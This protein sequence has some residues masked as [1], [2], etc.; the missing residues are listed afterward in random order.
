MKNL[1]KIVGVLTFFMIGFPALVIFV[2]F[3]ISIAHVKAVPAAISGG[4]LLV[5]GVSS[6]VI[7][8]MVGLFLNAG[9]QEVDR[10]SVPGMKNV[11]SGEVVQSRVPPNLDASRIPVDPHL[12]SQATKLHKKAVGIGWNNLLAVGVFFA[13]GLIPLRF[14]QVKEVFQQAA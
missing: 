10:A 12:Q 2:I 7:T 9:I 1:P 8:K 14:F 4:F 5:A 11:Y 3:V 6:F 13:C